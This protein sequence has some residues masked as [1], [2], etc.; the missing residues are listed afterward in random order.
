MPRPRVAN[1]AAVTSA[2]SAPPPNAS[3]PIVSGANAKETHTRN[4]PH[5]KVV[6]LEAKRTVTVGNYPTAERT[7]PRPDI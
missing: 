4:A 1:A 6:K 3:Q 7:N 5:S 2:T